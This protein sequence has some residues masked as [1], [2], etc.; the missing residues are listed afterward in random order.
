MTVALRVSLVLLVAGCSGQPPERPTP[1]TIIAQVAVISAQPPE[2]VAAAPAPPAAPAPAPPAAVPP[3]PPAEAGPLLTPEAAP[4]L[5]VRPVPAGQRV[6]R[7]S[8]P[9]SYNPR[10]YGP[11]PAPTAIP[12]LPTRQ[13]VRI[14]GDLRF[15]APGSARGGVALSPDGKRLALGTCLFDAATGELDA[16]YDIGGSSVH[17]LAFSPDGTRL[18]C[19]EGALSNVPTH[20]NALAVRDVPGKRQLLTIPTSDWALSGDGRL[21]AT[22]EMAPD[23]AEDAKDGAS[24]LRGGYHYPAVRLYDTKT[25]KGVAGYRVRGAR[26][27]AV[28]LS[29]DG[30]RVVVGC[31]DGTVRVWDR[32]AGRE[33]ATL[34]DLCGSPFPTHKPVVHLFAFS[35]DGKTL[36]AANARP[37]DSNTPRQVA[38]WRWPDGTL[39]YVKPA[40][41]YYDPTDL[42]FSP[43]GRHLFAGRVGGASVWDAAS[44]ERLKELSYDA[45]KRAIPSVAFKGPDRVFAPGV[46]PVLLAFPSLDP[47]AWPDRPFAARPPAPDFETV[48]PMPPEKPVPD[49]DPGHG[50]PGG[51][52]VRMLSPLDEREAGFEQTDAA[53]KRVRHYEAGRTGAYAVSPDAKLLVTCASARRIKYNGHDYGDWESPVRFWELATGRE[54]GVIR[55]YPEAQGAITFSPDGK[56]LLMPHFDG[57]IRLWDVATRKPTLALDPAGHEYDRLTFSTD[58]R[59]VVGGG[60]ASPVLVVWDATAP[61]R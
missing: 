33:V 56:Q 35:P 14:L 58:G 32:T 54:L 18:Y 12:V 27:T 26:P 47:V 8:Y 15:L 36:A 2:L 61:V 34:R 4:D 59:W 5:T 37:H 13:P 55:V 21:L 1:P 3:T 51:G 20:G 19:S 39:L 49:R 38:W 46:R 52:R 22:L 30:G 11:T 57:L 48:V 44:G 28:A 45:D 53:G 25:W 10:H 17:K 7:L 16:A 50:L 40:P 60:V 43:D 42:Q 31:D 9:E 23:A 24:S 29:P 6:S 41:N